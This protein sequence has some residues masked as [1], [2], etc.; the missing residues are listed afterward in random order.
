MS[1]S[2]SF[3]VNYTKNY[4]TDPVVFPAKLMQRAGNEEAG[5]FIFIKAGAA[6]AQYAWVGIT[7][8]GVATELTTTTVAASCAVGVAQIA[9]STNE[10]A[11]V[12]VGRGG[13]T[14]VG[15]KGKVAANYAAFA[16]I[17][18]TANVG[19][20]DDAATKVLGGVVGLTTDSGSGS[21]VELYAA[22]NIIKC[23]L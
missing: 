17:N 3:G 14:G 23:T 1:L 22:G 7:A 5:E 9:L 11:W 2:S 12:W 19:V 13:G 6:I 4:G 21:S 15:I 18:T 16:V 20:A 10:Y 8:A